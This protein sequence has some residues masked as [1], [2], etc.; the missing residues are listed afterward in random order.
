MKDNAYCF[1]LLPFL[2][3]L[4]LSVIVKSILLEHENHTEKCLEFSHLNYYNPHANLNFISM[5]QGREFNRLLCCLQ[6]NYSNKR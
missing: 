6:I 1:Q 3:Q 4:S 2:S 5:G